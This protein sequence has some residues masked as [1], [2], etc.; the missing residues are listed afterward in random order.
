MNRFDLPDNFLDNNLEILIKKTKARLRRN[1]SISSSSSS[2]LTNPPESED[3]PIVRSLTP[4]LD[5]MADKSLHEFFSSCY[6]QH[7]Y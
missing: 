4:Q 1:Q 7:L 3:Q 2:Q 5:I 6:D